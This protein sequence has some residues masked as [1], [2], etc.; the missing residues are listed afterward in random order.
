MATAVT[1]DVL[2]ELAGVHASS[3]WA[4]SI[5]LAFDPS[6]TPTIPDVETKF[7]AML[8]QAE[9]S[10]AAARGGRDCR[11]AVQ[12]DLARL[13]DWWDDDF[14]RDG[15]RGVAVFASSAD[16]FFRA[17]ALARPAGDS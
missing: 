14:E 17:L 3:G 9:K 10:A 16:G 1:T 6:S 11:I 13:R 12:D 15:A 8:A 2:R 7:N 5:Y 4:I